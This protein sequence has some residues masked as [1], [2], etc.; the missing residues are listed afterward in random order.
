MLWRFG[1]LSGCDCLPGRALGLGSVHRHRGAA[2][3]QARGNR[4]LKV[5]VAGA[6]EKL[7]Q[8]GQMARRAATV[9]LGIPAY[10]DIT[11]GSRT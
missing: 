6:R 10:C 1:A 3:V 11:G 5:S 8:H 2:C 9:H 7:A 4:G